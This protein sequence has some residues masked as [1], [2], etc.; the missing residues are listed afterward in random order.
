MKTDST[1]AT[2]FKVIIVGGGV[3]GLTLANCFERA[4]IHYVLLEAH[5]GFAPQVGSSTSIVPNGGRI[6]DQLGVYDELKAYS[7]WPA[8]DISWKY[9]G[10]LVSDIRNTAPYL[11]SRFC[12]KIPRAQ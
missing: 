6:L 12:C 2:G 11:V 4:G 7:A 5:S 9:D 3:A 10:E 1:K 8:G